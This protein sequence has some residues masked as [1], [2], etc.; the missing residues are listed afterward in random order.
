MPCGQARHRDAGT[1]HE[2]NVAGQRRK[3]ARLDDDV[4]L[5]RAVA[6]PARE[7]EHPLHLDLC[8]LGR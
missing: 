4:V 3:V 7:A 2:V 1:H 6:S 5:K 8:R